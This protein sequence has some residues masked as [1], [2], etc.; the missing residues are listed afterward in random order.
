MTR[1][2][3]RARPASARLTRLTP[4]NTRTL[5]TTGRGGGANVLL[6]P[7]ASIAMVAGAR[8]DSFWPCGRGTALACAVWAMCAFSSAN[9]CREEHGAARRLCARWRR[10]R[11]RRAAA[12]QPLRMPRARPAGPMGA[13]SKAREPAPALCMRPPRKTAARAHSCACA[14]RGPRPAPPAAPPR[15]EPKPPT[16][17]P[18]EA[19]RVPPASGDRRATDQGTGL[20]QRHKWPPSRATPPV[21]APSTC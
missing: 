21:H 15:D 20:Q 5:M 19:R 14:P 9:E 7:L 1:L 16:V 12:R 11:Q 10:A 4:E 8:G 17:S 3:S 18:L 2:P 13:R 6:A